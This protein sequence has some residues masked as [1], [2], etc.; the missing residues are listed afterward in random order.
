MAGSILGNALNKLKSKSIGDH[1]LSTGLGKSYD[2]NVAIAGAAPSPTGGIPLA[3]TDSLFNP[4][5]VFRYSKFSDANNKY[6]I[7]KHRDLKSNLT[8]DWKYESESPSASKIIEWSSKWDGKTVSPLGGTPYQANDFLWCK[9]YGKIPNNKLITLRRY[10]IPVEDNLQ[11]NKDNMPLVPIAQAVTWWGGD[12]G[13][14]LD[15]ILG[16]NFGLNWNMNASAITQDVNGNEIKLD[17]LLDAIGLKVSS[18][19]NLQAALKLIFTDSTTN[20]YA[21][22]GFDKEIQ[23]WVKSSY[24]ENGQYWN[25]VLGP[26][27]VI[28]QTA[29]RTQGYTFVHNVKLTFEY[30]LWSYN[31]I[32]PKVAMLDLISNFM[33][34]TYNSAE[35]WGGAARYFQQ[36]GAIIPGLPTM[37]FEKG[38]YIKGIQ[39]VIAYIM[40]MSSG[41]LADAADAIKTIGKGLSGD[42]SKDTLNEIASRV[43]KSN[44][45]KNFAGSR[46]AELMQKPLTMRSFLDGRAVGEWHITV[47][48][49]MNPIAVI[50]NLCLQNTNISFSDDVGLDDFPNS[51]K[52]EV[53]LEPGRPRAKQDIES[54]F[55]LGGGNLSWTPLPQPS[56][57]KNT[58]GAAN[59]IAVNLA[60][61]STST[62][63]VPTEEESRKPLISGQVLTKAD[64]FAYYFKNKVTNAYGPGFGNSPILVNYFTDLK[65]KD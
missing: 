37:S 19:P 13:N 29:V 36:T 8:T 47:G 30:S 41:K 33:S 58:Y 49:P 7:S 21:M 10:P 5:Y 63:T 32:N 42:I 61:N 60:N 18:S 39:E 12:T 23:D 50:G 55:N 16:M 48:N 40:A 64:N 27:N 44:V 31:N 46:V 14:T 28:N 1:I 3:G 53:T 9:H 2:P 35:F 54:M 43:E 52:F 56:S 57:A 26:V 51:I 6:D 62:A 59:T 20:P 38:D 65:T 4:F 11:I 17:S 45:V 25:R 34:L 24:G 22:N 15:N